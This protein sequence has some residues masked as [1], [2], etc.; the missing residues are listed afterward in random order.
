[1]VFFFFAVS[2]FSGVVAALGVPSREECGTLW[3]WSYCNLI[4]LIMS[5][6]SSSFSFKVSA[7]IIIVVYWGQRWFFFLDGAF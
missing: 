3:Y 1:M 5:L 7:I 4:S 6:T 2:L